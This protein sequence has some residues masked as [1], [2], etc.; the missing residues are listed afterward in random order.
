[1]ELHRLKTLVESKGGIVTDINTDAITCTFPDDKFPFDLI[2]EKNI[3]GYYWD[4]LKTV[5]KYKLEP[6][7]KRVKYPKLVHYMRFDNYT[8]HTEPWEITPDVP[9]NNFD[10]LINKIL[11][12][13]KSWL[14]NG[15]PGA[16]KT[17]L[18]NKIKEYLNNNGKV[19]KCLAPTNLAALLIDGTTVHKFACKLKKLTKFMETQLDYIFVDEVSMLHSNFYK[20]LMI[21]KQLKQCNI[22]VSGDFNQLDVI[23][24]LHKYDYKN[25]SILKELCDHN[26][27]NLQTCRRSNDKLFNLIQFDNINNLTPD[28][29][30]S[31]LKIDNE[32]NICWT[33]NTRKQINKKYMDVAYKKAKTSNYMTLKKLE[34]DDN[35]QDVIL[36][37]K[38]PLIAK[39]NNGNLKLIN[40]ER[41][42]I[43]KVDKNT[44]EIIIKNDRNEIKIKSDEFQKLFRIGYAFTTHSSQGM[45]IDK[46]YTIHEFNRMDQKL[47]Y[48][49]LSRATKH[50][51]INIIM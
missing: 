30:K 8:L 37:N 14:I 44:K 5:P 19:Y 13:N 2:D 18:I 10:P 48:V 15:P 25:S 47:K 42:I 31:D 45:S 7:A 39:V 49:A 41:Y 12:S 26:N 33:N 43:K 36:V 21:I 34:Y 11:D 29:F 6:N 4:E 51:N 22:I 32:I 28:D 9:D 46:P 24:D 27:I 38:T 20:I 40:N 50:E 17:T 16:G 23:G 35:S 1:M 3:N